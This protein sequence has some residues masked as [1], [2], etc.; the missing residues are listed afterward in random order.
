VGEGAAAAVVV[1]ER[2]AKQLGL[3]QPVRVVASAMHSGWNHTE[4][5]PD[6]VALCARD[7]YEE[8]GV[9][10]D[11]LDVIELHDASAMGE[12]M[13]YEQLG[14]CPKGE[15]AAWR[16]RGR[17]RWADASRSTPPA[18]CCARAIR[19][20]PPAWRRSWS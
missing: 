9:G 3:H 7:A 17:P 12:I 2:K 11:D 14:L 1:S 4:T 8:A 6:T 18:G 10:P 16:N 19:L 13:A 5:E 20:A 15:A